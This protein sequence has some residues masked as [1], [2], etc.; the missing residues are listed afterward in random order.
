MLAV[1]VALAMSEMRKNMTL[2]RLVLTSKIIMWTREIPP[3]SAAWRVC[4]VLGTC[5]DFENFAI[6]NLHQNTANW[7]LR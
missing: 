3:F 2:N 6:R 5:R 4:L 7:T 1:R